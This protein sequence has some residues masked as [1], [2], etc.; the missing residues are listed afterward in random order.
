M[1]NIRG[2]TLTLKTETEFVIEECCNCGVPF[3]MTD[4]HKKARLADKETFYCPNGH[5]QHYLG[6]THDQQLKDA[7][8]KAANALEEA[9]ITAARAEQL[10]QALTDA[11]RETKRLERRAT[12]G[13]CPCCD[14]TFVQLARHIKTKHPEFQS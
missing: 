13:A 12:A 8:R 10:A 6:K 4:T 3:A 2:T 11:R 14:R 9:R 1:P 5:P 7:E